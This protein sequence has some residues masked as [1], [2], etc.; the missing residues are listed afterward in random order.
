MVICAKGKVFVLEGICSRK[1]FAWEDALS[2]PIIC[3]IATTLLYLTKLILAV[4]TEAFGEEQ[5]L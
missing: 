4:H 1:G 5:L 3:D 2:I